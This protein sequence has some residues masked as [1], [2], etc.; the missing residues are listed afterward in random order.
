MVRTAGEEPDLVRWLLRGAAMTAAALTLSCSGGTTS[1]PDP[2]GSLRVLFIGNSLTQFNDLPEMVRALS[3]SAGGQPIRVGE[4]T[5]GGFSLQDHWHQGDALEAID[6]RQWD[7]V[8]MQQG[9][10]SLDE[11][12]AE[13]IDWAGR[14]AT[15]IRAAGGRPALYQVWPMDYRLDVMDRVLES[16]RLAA[17]G[18]QGK[19]L[20]AGAAW[21]AAWES[22]PGLPLYGSDGFHP[23]AMGSYL[24][25]LAIY[26]ELLDVSTMGLP[27]RLSAS[28]GGSLLVDVPSAQAAIL[29]AAADEATGAP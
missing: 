9:P 21:A 11:S 4:V 23:S 12:R 18:V 7:V 28:G 25:A 3:D 19:L 27:S 14:F 20:P 1:G 29:Q 6:S 15:R 5:F 8:V 2:S 26:G 22:N 17:E 24:A 13:L 16:Y 10:S